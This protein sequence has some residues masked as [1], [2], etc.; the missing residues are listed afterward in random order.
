MGPKT[1]S[2]R[3]TPGR[4]ARPR[5]TDVYYARTAHKLLDEAGVKHIY[6]EHPDGHSTKYA[7]KGLEEFVEMMKTVKR[8][9]FSARI[10]AVTKRGWRG[11]PG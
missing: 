4:D 6:C 7:T 9:P 10:V 11:G 2:L 3:G 8:D 1:P 5:F